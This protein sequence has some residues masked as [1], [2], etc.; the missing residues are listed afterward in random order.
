LFL[1][2]PVLICSVW[3]RVVFEDTSLYL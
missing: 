3:I 1:R 2:T